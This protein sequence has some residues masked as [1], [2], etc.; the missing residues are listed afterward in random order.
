M[1][2]SQVGSSFDEDRRIPMRLVL[3]GLFGLGLVL[4]SV[5]HLPSNRTDRFAIVDLAALSY[6]LAATTWLLNGWRPVVAKSCVVAGLAGIIHLSAV[7][8]G[9]PGLLVL[10]L[11]PVAVA[12]HLVG[13][14]PAAVLG[15]IES[16]SLILWPGAAAAGADTTS[17]AVT[18]AAIWITLGTV[19]RM[20]QAARCA[21]HD[22]ERASNLLDQV[23]NDKAALSQT[24]ETWTH[25][26]RQL[27]LANERI[28][29]LRAVAEEAQK[30]KAAFVAKV[31]HEFRTPLNMIIGLVS[32][33]VDTP[34]IYAEDLPP[35]LID[36][37]KIVHR[38]CEHL[39]SMVNDVL[40]LS[41]A[42]AGRLVLHRDHVDL[43]AII[44][45]AVGVVQPL[46]EKK[47]LSLALE[48]APRLPNVY[49]DQVR[50]RQVILNLVSNAA[51][52]TDH[53]WISVG[54]E[55]SD[56][57]VR[58]RVADTG[59]G[60][61]PHDLERIFEPFC[62]GTV[63]PLWQDRS[64][65]GLGL[66]ISRQFVELHGGRIWLE[67]ELGVGTQFFFTLPVA[68]PVEHTAGAG[69]WIKEDWRWVE[70]TF[71]TERVG[72][73]GHSSK[74]RV[75]VCDTTGDL[76]PA[77]AHLAEDVELVSGV[78]VSRT[79][80]TLR[81]CP[82]N[83]VIV[84]TA[85][86]SGLLPAVE[87][88]R[89]E[90]RDTPIIGCSMPARL[91][92]ALAAGAIDYLIKPIAR[93]DL[94]RALRSTAEPIRHVL[95]VDDDEDFLRLVVRMLAVCDPS[96]T[97]ST[98]ACGEEALRIL[99]DARVDLV[100]LDIMMGDLSGWEILEWKQRDKRLGDIPVIFVSAQ[101]PAEQPATSSLLVAAMGEGFSA[102][103]LL[104]CALGLSKLLLRSDGGPDPMLA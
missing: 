18:I 61:S 88:V 31:S 65:S 24:L 54:A 100:L 30:T 9:E 11:A 26:G 89:S 16:A 94:Q 78:D 39:A 51:R 32:L 47:N 59:P 86:P 33:M 80:E 69:R 77:L 91:E 68:S 92:R 103:K 83:V 75:V 23:R 20:H 84:N 58:I 50:I 1:D 95:V 29:M 55:A 8:L 52:F 72:L 41:Q 46:L 4:V 14:I 19:Y 98:A 5:S 102:T 34:D 28:G 36:D 101:D 76:Y 60:I 42:E 53:G 10:L 13:L 35:E 38:N 82:A 63:Q 57:H 15:V 21:S 12:L 67:S 93:A 17:I 71:R 74:P 22:L 48:I 99:R 7:W 2:V 81:E 49:C 43:A 97:V 85:G 3:V 6:A 64:G 66:S 27:A 44:Q 56:D 25:A 87:R 90:I 73:A 79:V 70:T 45:E 62:Q 96:L 37:L 40:D 104:R